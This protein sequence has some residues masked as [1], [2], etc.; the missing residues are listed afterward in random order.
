M[1]FLDDHHDQAAHFASPLII[2]HV[3]PVGIPSSHTLHRA[4]SSFLEADSKSIPLD[5]SNVT[6]ARHHSAA[7][8]SPNVLTSMPGQ[9]CKLH[10]RHGDTSF[11]FGFGS[12]KGKSKLGDNDDE[13]EQCM[14][15]AASG[16]CQSNPGGMTMCEY[17]CGWTK[18]RDDNTDQCEGW[19]A[20]GQC[21]SN[22][23]GMQ[24]CEKACECNKLKDDEDKEC[25]ESDCSDPGKFKDANHD[26]LK[27]CNKIC[28]DFF[29]KLYATE[30]NA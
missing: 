5:V 21:E 20:D 16:Q 15:W 27:T 12:K 30:A 29:P 8:F 23:N 13:S 24:G 26:C 25:K 14:S 10:A 4:W 1:V 28:R 19:A 11:L 7:S 22:P 9:A 2:E 3:L 18:L 6:P 17:A